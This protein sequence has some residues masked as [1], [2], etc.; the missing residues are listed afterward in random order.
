MTEAQ[1]ET[2]AV[3]IKPDRGFVQEIKAAGGDSV[4]NCF[5]CATCS[6]VCPI[7]PEES[8]F[9]RKEMIWAGWGLK[10][11]LVKDPDIW[12]CHQCN[13]CSSKCPRG[14]RPGDVLAAAR[15][16][17]F[18]HYATPSFLGKAL[19]KPE[20]LIP[21][22]LIPIALVGLI[23]WKGDAY[24]SAM[25][26]F[27]QHDS[28]YGHHFPLL[29]VDTLFLSTVG[30]MAISVLISLNRFWKDLVIGMPGEPKK[31][32]VQAAITTV[33][34]LLKHER[35]DKCETAKPR[36]LGHMLTLYGMIALFVTT[37]FVFLGL[38]LAGMHVPMK[39]YNPI[40]LLGIAGAVSFFVGLFMIWNNRQNNAE[41]AGKSTYEDML[42]IFA[43]VVVAVTGIASY[44]LR[45]LSPDSAHAA[46]AANEGAAIPV[47]AVAVYYAHLV[48]VWFLLAYLPFSK[49][50]HIVY[51]TFALIRAHQVDRWAPRSK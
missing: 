10:D 13:D 4:K 15:K 31:T 23:F 24:N 44:L 50:A 1:T 3:R 32:F 47:V 30:L 16:R 26:T 29:A 41:S 48:T 18:A 43:L 51:R 34:E 22:L 28:W 40:K 38:Y 20:M 7:S 19:A 33:V 25:P 17:S 8:P 36:R 35:F 6:T 27:L 21:L 46:A 2:K 9:P 11:R 14:A 39:I 42:F 12:L 49:F 45:L 37:T 5:Q